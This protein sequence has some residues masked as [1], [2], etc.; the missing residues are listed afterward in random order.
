[1]ALSASLGP[2]C[3]TTVPLLGFPQSRHTAIP[4]VCNLANTPVPTPCR[5]GPMP[6]KFRRK[7]EKALLGTLA[8]LGIAVTVLDT[9]GVLDRASMGGIL[10]KITLLILATV[11][12][13]L[14]FEVDR[15]EA[16]DKIDQRLR[17]RDIAC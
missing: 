7:A 13:Y 10:P 6:G 8:T 16:A 15:F 1:M 9:L 11:A 2:I 4:T 17:A 12:L 3:T 14:L 5:G